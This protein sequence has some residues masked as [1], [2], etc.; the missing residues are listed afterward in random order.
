MPAFAFSTL[1]FLSALALAGTIALRHQSPKVPAKLSFG[2]VVFYLSLIGASV[3]LVT[4]SKSDLRYPF[5]AFMVVSLTADMVHTYSLVKAAKQ[6][7][8]PTRKRFWWAVIDNSL[9][10]II[11]VVL[12]LT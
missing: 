6:G 8:L 3:I 4:H 7:V 1:F 2:M 11:T 9:W 10:L 5:L 12:F